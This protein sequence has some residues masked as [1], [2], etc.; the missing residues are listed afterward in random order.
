MGVYLV[1]K[2]EHQELCAS[3]KRPNGHLKLRWL[4]LSCF[5][6]K[7]IQLNRVTLPEQSPRE[8][9]ASPQEPQKTYEL[10][11]TD[12]FWQSHRGR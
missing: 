6:L 5:S 2:N 11:P 10:L 4:F 12:R 1:K 8:D 7:D 9:G 3:A